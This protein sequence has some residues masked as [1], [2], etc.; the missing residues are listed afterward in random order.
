MERFG[1]GAIPKS[2][3]RMVL[4]SFIL[5]VAAIGIFRQY[6]TRPDDNFEF[7]WEM[8]RIGR[9]IALGHGFSSPYDGNTG[10]TA[11]EPPLYPF[12][13]GGVF[14]VFGI[15]TLAS[16]WVLLSINSLFATIT[17]IPV[18]LIAR[19]ALQRAPSPSGRRGP[20]RCVPTSGTGRSTGYGTRPLLRSCWPAYFCFRWNCRTGRAG[21]DGVLWSGCRELARWPI[22]RCSP[23]FPSADYGFGGSDTGVACRPWRRCACRPASSS[24]SVALAGA[25]LRGLWALRLSSRRFRIASSLGQRTYADGMLMAYLQPNLNKLELEKFQS[26][27][28]LAYA[29]SASVRHLIGFARIPGASPSSA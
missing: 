4:L 24:G 1:L 13:I 17:S 8:G 20:G 11:W 22:P 9:S 28:E 18:F 6:H 16:A 14:K 3:W 25:E 2:V 23:F 26:M 27:G 19:K 5:Q 10:P 21:A 12:L 7:G 15:Y 29:E